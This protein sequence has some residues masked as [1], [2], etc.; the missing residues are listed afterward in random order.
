MKYKIFIS[1]GLT[2]CV[3]LNLSFDGV[4]SQ[5]QYSDSQAESVQRASGASIKEFLWDSEE[6]LPG[7]GNTD[8]GTNH[9][10]LLNEILHNRKMGLNGQKTALFDATKKN[11]ILYSVDNVQGGNLKHLFIDEL[12]GAQRLDF[13]LCY[14]SD[15]ELHLYT[16]ENASLTN[17]VVDQTN[18]TV[19]KSI[20]ISTN[21]TWD[22]IG[23]MYGHSVV[24]RINNILTINPAEWESGSH[25]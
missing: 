15:T 12:Q 14:I 17:G 7:E 23:T 3:L 19:Y 20:L 13:V 16:F 6:I 25:L 9:L 18:I 21:G 4:W 5:W 1:L 11:V 10:L 22:S 8:I 24:R 2:L